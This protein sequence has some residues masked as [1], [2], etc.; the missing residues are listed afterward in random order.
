MKKTVFYAFILLL[1]LVFSA[2]SDFSSEVN[3]AEA[4]LKRVLNVSNVIF[5]VDFE[6]DE[7]EK[8]VKYEYFD[9]FQAYVMIVYF[10]R[11]IN[12]C[13]NQS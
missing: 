8:K 6:I 9:G 12:F 7:K 2:C 11:I 10:I 1:S 4:Q 5:N 3:E 13:I